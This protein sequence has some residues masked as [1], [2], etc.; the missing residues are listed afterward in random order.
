VLCYS[1]PELDYPFPIPT[2]VHMVGAM[3]PPLPQA[4]DGGDVTAWLDAQ[5]SVV[6]QAFG[7]V[8]RLDAEEVHALVDVARR[9][10]GHGHQ[11]LWK[12]PEQQQRLL[13]PRDALPRNLRIESW[14]PS[15]LDVL[16]HPNVKLF[17]NHCGGNAFHEGLYFGKPQVMRSLFVDCHDQAIRGYDAGIGLPVR[18]AAIDTDDVTDKLLRVLRDRRF[19][20]RAELFAALQRAAGGRQ[21]AADIIENLPQLARPS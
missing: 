16:A 2:K 19:R 10:D 21:A 6:Y 14:L 12:L 20:E 1:V 13:P 8:T 17:F 9:L 4:P 11:V 18:P 5:T 3:V 15:Q 7:T